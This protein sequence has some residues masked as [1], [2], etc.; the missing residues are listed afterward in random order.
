MEKENWE[1]KEIVNL[2]LLSNYKGCYLG[3]GVKDRDY[4][5]YYKGFNN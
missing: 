1:R 3:P 5:I 4:Y 2:L